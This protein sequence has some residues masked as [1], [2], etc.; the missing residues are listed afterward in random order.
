MISLLIR[1]GRLA[2]SFSGLVMLPH[3]LFA[4]PFALTAIVLAS[5]ETPV[6][7]ETIGLIVL[8]FT[9]ARS[10]AMAFNRL[11][12]HRIDA[13]NP[14]TRHRHLPTGKLSRFQVWSFVLGSVVVFEAAAYFLGPLP[15]ALSPVALA[16]IFFYSYTKF[17]TTASHWVLGLALSIAPV[18]A[19]IA[20]SGKFSP[21]VLILAGAVVFWVA[22]FDII[23]ALQDESFDLK[24]GLFSLPAG[25][26]SAGALI[27]SRICHLL[28]FLLLVLVGAFFPVGAFYWTGCLLVA[29][30]LVFEH[31]LV[32]PGDL[33]RVDAA[34]FNVNGTVSIIF[35]GLNLLDRLF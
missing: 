30:M 8:A 9:G 29:V 33:S 21:G 1:A 35:F 15:F 2:H 28:A 23:Y 7:L 16:V 3:T 19:Y 22:G 6:G 32:S 11:L 27:V 4:L 24:H 10:A 5:Y 13:R 20:V 18:G 26:G 12:D 17:F 34:F 25:L 31:S 14:R